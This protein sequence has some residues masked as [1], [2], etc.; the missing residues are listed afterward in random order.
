MSTEDKIYGKLEVISS[1]VKQLFKD[2]EMCAGDDSPLLNPYLH[3][4]EEGASEYRENLKKI[5]RKHTVK[6]I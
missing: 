2:T 6:V 1:I 3:K 4:I 5:L